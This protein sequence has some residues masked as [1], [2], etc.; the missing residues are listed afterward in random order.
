MLTDY[1]KNRAISK[2][3]GPE[4]HVELTD[5]Q[6]EDLYA[7]AKL[8]WHLYSDFSSLSSQKLNGIQYIWIDRYFQ[9]LC[10]ETLGRIRGKYKGSLPIPGAEISLEYDTL[11]KESE[12]EK[13]ELISLL[14]PSENKIMLAVYMNVGNIADEDVSKYMEKITKMLSTDKSY[15]FFLMPVRGNQETKIECIYPNF[16]YDEEMKNKMNNVLDKLIEN[17]KTNE[18]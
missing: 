17:T 3:G 15:K 14:V 11:L 5:N 6:M 10:K 13:S 4:I 8:D 16:L 9:A 2:L 1:L 18:Q 12:Q 7:N